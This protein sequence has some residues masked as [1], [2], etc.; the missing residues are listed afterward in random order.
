M[1]LATSNP[2]KT[3]KSR[4]AFGKA[5]TKSDVLQREQLS[6]WFDAVRRISNPT[7]S[8]CLRTI[9]LTGARP[10]EVLALRWDDVNTRWKGLSIRDKAECTREI[11][12]TPYV[13]SLLTTLPRRSHWVLAGANG[14]PISSPNHVLASAGIMILT[15]P[16]ATATQYSATVI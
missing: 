6:A 8:A 9:L 3:R 14:E 2:A 16:M 5:Q 12:L 7:M 4:E 15:T 11:P 1:V 10:G 13:E